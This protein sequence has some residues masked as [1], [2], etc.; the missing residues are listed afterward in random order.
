LL[1]ISL[2]K[3]ANSAILTH[4][5]DAMQHG[6]E[7]MSKVF[8]TSTLKGLRAAERYQAAL[9]SKFDKVTVVPVGLNRVRVSGQN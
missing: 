2:D 6:G 8:D 1:R 3:L 9:Y 5:I 7:H 4:V